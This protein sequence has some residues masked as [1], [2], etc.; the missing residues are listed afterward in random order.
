MKY[1]CSVFFVL[2]SLSFLHSQVDSFISLQ[3]LPVKGGMVLSI[4]NDSQD[5]IELLSVAKC[6]LEKTSSCCGLFYLEQDTFV[7]V[8]SSVLV[9]VV[10]LSHCK[11]VP[12]LVVGVSESGSFSSSLSVKVRPLD[13]FS[14]KLFFKCILTYHSREE[15]KNAKFIKVVI[16]R[17]NRESISVSLHNYK[18]F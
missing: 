9:P 13:S 5:T 16:W 12:V 18:K 8:L 15:I 10:S 4:R 7:L 3:Y 14:V 17:R 11:G 6:F 2:S 1:F